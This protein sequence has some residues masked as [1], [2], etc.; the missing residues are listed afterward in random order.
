MKGQHSIFIQIV[1]IFKCKW[2]CLPAVINFKWYVSAID[3]KA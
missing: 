3:K 2:I 1:H